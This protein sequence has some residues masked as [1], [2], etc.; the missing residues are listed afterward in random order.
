LEDL[1]RIV[2]TIGQAVR[3][4][5]VLTYKPDRPQELV[6]AR[7]KADQDPTKH[8]IHLELVPKEKFKGYF[9]PYYKPSYRSIPPGE[10]LPVGPRSSD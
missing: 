10:S 9:L 5:Y 2:Q 7:D 3:Y 4:R 8:K 1:P 6:T